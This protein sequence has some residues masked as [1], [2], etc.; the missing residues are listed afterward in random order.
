MLPSLGNE[1]SIMLILKPDKHIT[2]YENCRQGSL[3]NINV[4]ILRKVSAT[5]SK[6]VYK[7]LYNMTKWEYHRYARLG[8]HWKMK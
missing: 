4:K 7:E 1:A 3:M 6:N 8:H 5:K 2:G